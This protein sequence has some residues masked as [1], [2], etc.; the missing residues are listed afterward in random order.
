MNKWKLLATTASFAII[1]AGSANA[2]VI[3]SNQPSAFIQGSCSFS[4]S[5]ASGSG[6]AA[7]AFSLGSAA[8]ITSGS[9]EEFD[10]GISPT[11]VNYA[12]YANIASLPGGLALF[13]GA[14]AI[15]ATSEGFNA[16]YNHG[17]ESFSIASVTLGPGNYFFALQAVSP[18]HDTYLAQ[19]LVD[20]GAV[21]SPDGGATWSSGYG[22]FGGVAIALFGNATQVPEPLTLSLFGAGF[23]C[24][25][26]VRRRRR[27]P[28]TPI[29]SPSPARAV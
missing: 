8:T 12:F 26:A 18:V 13:S 20:A 6:F 29:A 1:I 11:S 27:T 15:T 21:Q 7:Q 5:C 9:F 3:Y 14:A 4:T 16:P 28:A 17:L 24:A 19:G 2:A 25:V 23:A 10:F 22:S